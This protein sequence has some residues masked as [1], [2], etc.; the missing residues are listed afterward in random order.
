MVAEKEKRE[1][2]RGSQV[3]EDVEWRRAVD[4]DRFREMLRFLLL[5]VQLR[6]LTEEE[7]RAKL[8]ERRLKSETPTEVCQCV[9]LGCCSLMIMFDGQ[10]CL[11]SNF[12]LLQVIKTRWTCPSLLCCQLL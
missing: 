9:I 12:P 6:F 11:S 10:P 8:E 5:Q 7:K 2:L 1:V 4:F 3:M